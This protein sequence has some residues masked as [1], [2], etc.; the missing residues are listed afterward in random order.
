MDLFNAGVLPA[1]EEKA[2]DDGAIAS[3]PLLYVGIH[4]QQL[5][6]QESPNMVDRVASIASKPPSDNL[7]NL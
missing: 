5:Y 1:L 2:S 6:V 7:S 4:N 3:T